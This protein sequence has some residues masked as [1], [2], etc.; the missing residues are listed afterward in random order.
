MSPGTAPTPDLDA[1][2]VRARTLLLARLGFL[3]IALVSLLVPAWAE[4]LG[5]SA[6]AAPVGFVFIAAYTIAAY[7]ILPTRA[8]RAATFGAMCLDLLFVVYLVTYSGGLRSPLMVVQ[9][10]YTMIFA[11]LF[12]RPLGIV[13]PLLTLPVVARIDQILG[14]DSGVIELLLLLW[15]AA[16]NGAIVAAI[17]FLH[18]R[19]AARAREVERLQREKAELLVAEERARLAREIHDGLGASL[20]GLVLQADFVRKKAGPGEI[21]DE[22]DSLRDAAEES[23]DELRRSVAMLRADFD[24]LPALEELTH[25]F[26]DR[27]HVEATFEATGTRTPADPAVQLACFR[28]LQEAL[29]NVG[30]HAAARHVT[31]RAGPVGERFRIEVSD[32]G[33]GFDPGTIQR[34]HYGLENMRARAAHMAG[35]LAIDSAPGKGTHI[36]LSIPLAPPES[37]PGRI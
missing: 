1:F 24:L 35:T 31:V 29:A 12:P 32:D 25:A 15:Y 21:A 22:L 14:G 8:A 26:A 6:P 10:T 18:Q 13:P 28:V 33:G 5:T 20:S 16:V 36:E 19:E 37:P 23:V 2:R 34:Q 11:L 7:A 30:K 9:L 27:T 4:L 3:V 17:V